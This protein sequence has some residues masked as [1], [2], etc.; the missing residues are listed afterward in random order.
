M[1]SQGSQQREEGLDEK[2]DQAC[3]CARPGSHGPRIWGEV[4]PPGWA[5][6]GWV[7]E[8]H[9]HPPGHELSSLPL[10][11]TWDSL[12]M[13]FHGRRLDLKPS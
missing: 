3:C 4:G 6:W 2:G 11:Y 7:G 5:F 1:V 8:G 13:W 9:V 10:M 12:T